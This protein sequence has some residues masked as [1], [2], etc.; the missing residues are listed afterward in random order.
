MDYRVLVQRV[1]VVFGF[2]CRCWGCI[3]GWA[4]L[5][6]P[7]RHGPESYRSV[8]RRGGGRVRRGR[9]GSESFCRRRAGAHRAGGELI[10]GRGEGR[11][12]QM[13]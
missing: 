13:R 8:R 2:G 4:G 12:R 5:V 10:E 9:G 11:R 7:R 3:L 1:F 6:S